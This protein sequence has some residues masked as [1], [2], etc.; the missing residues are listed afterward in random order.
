MLTEKIEQDLI[1]AMKARD[2]VRVSTLRMLKS[3]LQ[4]VK[5]DKRLEQLEDADAL[6]VISKEVKK[7][8]DSIEGFQKGNRADL[9][10]KETQEL[11]ILEAYLPKAL[12]EE[13]LV[14][15]VSEVI[16]KAGA[17]TKADMGKVMKLVMSEVAGRADGRRVSELVAQKLV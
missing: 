11:Q 7:H 3:A 15:I 14:R 2:A 5:I 10:G 4:M 16:Q 13:E 17:S 8:R 9:V 6:G 1:S 12:S